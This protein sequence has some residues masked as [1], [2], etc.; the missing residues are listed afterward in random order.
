MQN[1][2]LSENGCYEIIG[3]VVDASTIKMLAAV[4]FN[5]TLGECLPVFL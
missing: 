4:N 1:A 3:N 5:S 2:N